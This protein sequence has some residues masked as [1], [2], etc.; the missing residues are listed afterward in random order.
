MFFP[1]EAVRVDTT[2]VWRPPGVNI[3]NAAEYI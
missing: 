3:V 1:G 2:R